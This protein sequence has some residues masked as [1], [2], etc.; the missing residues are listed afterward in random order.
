MLEGGRKSPSL[1]VLA[2]SYKPISKRLIKE[3]KCSKL[4]ELHQAPHLQH[5]F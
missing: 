1:L 2:T 3:R 5:A 4:R